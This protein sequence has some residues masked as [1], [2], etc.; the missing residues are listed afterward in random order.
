LSA[1]VSP[2]VQSGPSCERDCACAFGDA[3]KAEGNVAI[4][5]PSNIQRRINSYLRDRLIRHCEKRSDDAIQSCR[6][7]ACWIA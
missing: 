4:N 2:L 3:S 5:V 1:G 6:F 7:A